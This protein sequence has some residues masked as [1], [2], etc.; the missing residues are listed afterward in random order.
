[1]NDLSIH[2]DAIVKSQFIDFMRMLTTD[3]DG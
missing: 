1:M 3:I 2:K